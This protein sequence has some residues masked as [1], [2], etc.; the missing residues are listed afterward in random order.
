MWVLGELMLTTEPLSIV[1]SLTSSFWFVCLPLRIEPKA[2]WIRGKC[3]TIELIHL[4][5]FLILRQGLTKLPRLALNSFYSLD[6][7]LKFQSSCLRLL[8]WDYRSVPLCLGC[9]FV[10]D[11]T[12][13]CSAD[14]PGVS[15]WGE[16]Q[17]LCGVLS[18][19]VPSF[20]S[21]SQHSFCLILSAW[22]MGVSTRL[23][24]R[25]S[26]VYKTKI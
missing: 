26:L 21:S 20:A 14:S 1:V 4:Y 3:T 19:C 5:F 22:I 12:L 13:F 6:K 15:M 16:S 17:F 18:H 9:L 11:R 2:L 8:Y 25:P 24:Y 7:V 23:G 10:E